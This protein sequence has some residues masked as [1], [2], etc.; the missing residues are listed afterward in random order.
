MLNEKK[1]NH[2]VTLHSYLCQQGGQTSLQRDN[3]CLCNHTWEHA[4]RLGTA[5]RTTESLPLRKAGEHFREKEDFR[6]CSELLWIWSWRWFQ[7][8]CMHTYQDVATFFFFLDITWITLLWRVGLRQSQQSFLP[9]LTAQTRYYH[10]KGFAILHLL[11]TE[12]LETA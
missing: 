3:R 6:F 1:L 7:N 12:C 9:K 11:H 5:H 2:T 4:E 10:N 8:A